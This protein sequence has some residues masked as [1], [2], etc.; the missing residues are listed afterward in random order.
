MTAREPI[1]HW[2]ETAEVVDGYRLLRAAEDAAV[3]PWA[4]LKAVRD[5]RGRVVDFVYH[6]INCIAA[7]QQRLRPE[8]LI[9]RSVADTLPEVARIGLIEQYAHCVDTGEPLIL[10]DLTYYG[11]TLDGPELETHRYEMRGVRVETEY[12]SLNWR[13]VNQRYVTAEYVLQARERLRAS[14]DAMLDPQV[15]LEAVRDS[16]GAIVDF[17]YREVNKAACDYLGLAREDLLGHGVVETM[18]GIET[19]L[20]AGYI[21]CLDTGEPLV[22][23]DFCYDNEILLDARH[24]DLRAT[25]VAANSL[26]LTWRDVT[27]RF[28]AT[29]RIAESEE[30]FR[31][32]AE[33][34]GDVVCRMSDDGTFLWISTAVKEALGAPPEHYIGRK[35]WDNFFWPVDGSALETT[36]NRFASGEP[37]LGRTRF[38]GADG[39]PHWVHLF[40]K[41]YLGVDGMR[42]GMLA[43]FRVIDDEV[44]AEQQVEEAHLFQA[45]AQTLLHATVDSMLTPQ[46]LLEAVRDRAGQV[47]DF[48]YR[49]ANLAF[50]AYRG[51][52]ERD[53]I[54]QSLL[55]AQPNLVGAGLIDRY[56]NCVDTG[57]SV[58]LDDFG[59][60]NAMLDDERRYDIRVVRAGVDLISLTFSDVTERYQAAQRISASERSY[61]LLAENSSD[62]V[63]HVR[64]GRFAWTSPSVADVVGA[65]PE[66]WVG[67]PV[68]EI[69][70]PEDAAAFARRLPTLES[71]GTAQERIRVVAV[72]GVTHWADLHA[73]PLYDDGGHQDGFTAALR[74]VDDEVAAQQDAEQARRQQARADALYR[75]SVD[76][77]AVGMCL[78]DA[79]GG[80]VDVNEAVCEF[81][82]YDAE[83]LKHKTWQ[84]LT[85]EKYLQAD[86]DKVADV[87]AGRI[88]SYRMTKEYRHADGHPIWGDLSVGCVRDGDG[89]VEVF[90]S[91]INDITAEVQAR[92][93]L[94]LS[95]ERNRVLAQGLQ[96]ELNSAA[97]YLQSVLPGDMAGQVSVSTRYLP[98]NTLGGDCFDF[99]WIDDDHMVVYLLDVSGHGVESALIA[100]SVHNMLRS[101]S[102]ATETMLEP[103]RVLAALNQQFGMDQHD[104]NYF[105]IFY[106]VYQRS[107]ATLLYSNA[108]HPPALLLTGGQVTEL[109][110]QSFPVGMFDDTPF[111]TA[112]VPIPPGSQ[113]LLYSDGAYELPLD[114]GGQWPLRAFVE[115]CTR[116]GGSP[117]W[118]LDDVI[119]N[120][121]DNSNTGSFDDD[122]CLVRF[123]FD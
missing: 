66:Y 28:W 117:D 105:T 62:M 54:G 21:R 82:G 45:Q 97:K 59:L 24:Y 50:C 122:C 23:N 87:L 111:T 115:L 72:D 25:R 16:S 10:D 92:E 47:V 120:V 107:S 29:Q 104:G 113:L 18:P 46:M 19:T 3:E 52:E 15:L 40:L 79:E 14:A 118:T 27:D 39:T 9:G 99:R 67:R 30:R 73:R 121:L 57:E 44:A 64:D 41:P 63:T 48:V 119:H 1:S 22:L 112:T 101:A 81:F 20:L 43:T 94:L 36:M 6:D 78:I 17:A 5:P 86:L 89:H 123:K 55:E 7:R 49:S 109:P 61:R 13:D 76:S 90:V 11:R 116:L 77:A 93:E 98:S 74:L 69:I 102:F 51:W 38:R 95:E 42:D 70:P 53:I 106:G 56:A 100:V 4:L 65:S 103:G 35:V 37:Y 85:A 31:L 2:F 88:E 26:T 68:R 91:Q 71:G 83:A 58:V 110:S 96:S 34:V 12:L 33:N 8:D 60:V 114:D 108:G 80:F 75:R 32:L 84:E